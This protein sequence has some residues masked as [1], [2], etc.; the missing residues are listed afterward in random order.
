VTKL[1]AF[2]R[3]DLQEPKAEIEGLDIVDGHWQ[4]N[5]VGS[6]RGIQMVFLREHNGQLAPGHAT[7]D[8]H[9][10]ERLDK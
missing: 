5:V 3:E 1:Q 2:L 9:M 4:G 8:Y 10:E 7:D 6:E